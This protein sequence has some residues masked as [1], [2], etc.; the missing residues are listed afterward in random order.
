MDTYRQSGVIV[1]DKPPKISSAQV[2]AHVKRIVGAQKAGHT[3]TLDP[4][5]TGVLVC[6]LNGAT[7]LAR[8]FLKGG[9]KYQ[10]VLHLGV[11]TDTQDSSGTI[12]SSCNPMAFS[13]RL[14]G[15]V[16]K[17]FEGTIEQIPPIYSALKYRG[18]PL[19]RHARKG[20]PVQKPPRRVHIS[21]IQILEVNLPLVRF[22]ISCSAGTYIRTLCSDIGNSLGCGGHLQEL[23]RIESSNF[24][25]QEALPLDELE[26]LAMYGDISKR[27]I[28]MA[29]ALRSMPVVV[30]D[31]RLA[32]KIKQGKPI[33]K[34]DF[35]QVQIT[36]PKGFIKFID[37]ANRLIAVVKMTARDDRLDYCCV[38]PNY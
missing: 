19:Y 20:N 6:C 22:E 33:S 14:I 38:F 28:N 36:D 15:S 23:R 24:T 1:I 16:I 21:S 32:Q 3:G 9:K 2:V 26:K 11:Q 13:D 35:N 18:V 5:A 27:I 12:I 31:V 25:I 7:K 10:A 34:T 37:K 29:D 30:A 8:F 4:F 17:K